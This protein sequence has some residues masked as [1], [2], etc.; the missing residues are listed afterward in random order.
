MMSI[1]TLNA[2]ADSWADFLWAG[3]LDT[4][5]ILV[6]VA[7]VWTAIRRWMPASAS[8]EQRAPAIPG[9]SGTWRTLSWA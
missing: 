2:G 4:T 1:D 6:V 8:A 9:R 3:L 7:A 5:V